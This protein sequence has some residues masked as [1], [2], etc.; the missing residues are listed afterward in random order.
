MD[1]QMTF[2]LHID[3]FFLGDVFFFYYDV[4]VVR[5]STTN[6]DQRMSAAVLAWQLGR[7]YQMF[8]FKIFLKMSKP[9]QKC[10]NTWKNIRSTSGEMA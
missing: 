5:C 3:G 7:C 6:A 2:G 8:L 4:F 9:S 1:D 10:Q